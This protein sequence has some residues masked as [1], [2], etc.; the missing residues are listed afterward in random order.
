MRVLINL[1]IIFVAASVIHDAFKD[2]EDA[3]AE[4]SAKAE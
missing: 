1:F 2:I 3:A 4:K